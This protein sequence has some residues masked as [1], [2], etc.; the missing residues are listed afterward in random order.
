MSGVVI[1]VILLFCCSILV[2]GGYFGLEWYS[3]NTGVNLF[4]GGCNKN[5]QTALNGKTCDYI[6]SLKLD[7]EQI[8]FMKDNGINFD[9][10]GRKYPGESCWSNVIENCV[11]PICSEKF[12]TPKDISICRFYYLLQNDKNNSIK[13]NLADP[14]VANIS[15]QFNLF[16]PSFKADGERI[17]KIMY[18]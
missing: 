9:K 18:G 10:L 11:P 6:Q 17:N 4:G 16:D 1:V 13:M 12:T 2:V 14:G 3:K 7:D 15:K 8:K 5:P